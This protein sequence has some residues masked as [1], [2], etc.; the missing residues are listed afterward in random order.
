MVK[1]KTAHENHAPQAFF[2]RPEIGLN[3]HL[4]K[5]ISVNVTDK[6]S[7]IVVCSYI[8][9]VFGKNIAYDLIYGI[10]TLFFKCIVNKRKRLLSSA[11]LSS[12]TEKSWSAHYS[13]VSTPFSNLKILYLYYNL[14]FCKYKSFYK[15][16]IF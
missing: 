9:R 1:T 11:S 2:L 15:F 7:R 12:Y 3:K 14:N 16:H 13:Q 10:V 5:L 6:A 8:G 4:Q